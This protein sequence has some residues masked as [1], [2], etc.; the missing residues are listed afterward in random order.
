M[1]YF[2]NSKILAKSHGAGTYQGALCMIKIFKGEG[3]M[4]REGVSSERCLKWGGGGH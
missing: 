2:V 1:N 4:D 3:V